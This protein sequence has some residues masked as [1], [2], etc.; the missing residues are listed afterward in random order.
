M[1]YYYDINLHFDDYYINYYEWEDSEHFNRLPVYKVANIKDF[2]E[3]TVYIDT[4]FK[5][6]IISDGI[7]SIAL[8]IIDGKSIYLSSLPYEDEFKINRIIIDECEALKYKVLEKRNTKTMTRIDLAKE[9]MLNLLKTESNDFIKFL[10]YERTGKLSSDINKMT[11][12]LTEDIKNNFYFSYYQ[13]YDKIIIG[14]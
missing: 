7:T 14:E 4:D 11:K 13:L 12:Y 6:I 10:Y 2:L 1:Q 3:N 8:E 9:K 5:N